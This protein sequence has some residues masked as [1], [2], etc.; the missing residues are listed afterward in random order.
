MTSWRVQHPLDRRILPGLVR[1]HDGPVTRECAVRA[2][3]APVPPPL[4][5]AHLHVPDGQAVPR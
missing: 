1:L 4:E 5:H 3:C 2:F